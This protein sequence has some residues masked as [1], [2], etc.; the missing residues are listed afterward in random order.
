MTQPPPRTVDLFVDGRW[1]P[2]RDGQYEPAA[3]PVTGQVIGQV[4][5]GGRADAG[6]AV[7]VAGR[8]QGGWAAATAFDRAQA[9]HRIADA[10]QRRRDELARALTLDQG[11]PLHAEAYP[12]VDDLIGYWR[13]AA[14]DVLRLDGA[15]PPSRLPGARVLIERRPLGVVAVI[16]PWNWPYTMPAQVIAPALAAG[17]TVVWAPAPSTSVCSAVLVDCIADAGLPPGTVSFVPGPG[18]VVGDEIAGHPGVAAV[19]FVGSTRT[20]LSVA[21]RAAGKAQ[22]LEMGNNGPLVVMDDADLDR[23]VA[24]AIAGA[25]L[26][27]GQSCTAAERIL[28]HEA[29]RD[30]FVAAFAAAAAEQVVLGD[31]FAAQTSMGPLNNA[32]VA[33]KT[34]RHVADALARGARLIAGGSA[35]PGWP[36]GLYWQ[37]TILDDVPRDAV[38]AREETFGPV[39]PVIGV[40][41]LED[42]IALTND[43]PY[44]LMASIYTADAGTGLRYADAIRAAWVNVNE[45][46]NYWETHLPFGGGGGSLSGVGRVGGRYAMEALTQV[47]T[48]VLSGFA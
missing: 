20:G 25:F 26:C 5:Q 11:K 48:M 43:L 31:P 30:A 7:A 27:A 1:Q 12:E 24:G 2:P 38:V 16:T 8:A 44:G 29:V 22:L 15:I 32:G 41:S 4:A 42:A 47:R 28:V 19:A 6:A 34:A 45:S 37:A 10:C 46:S 3:S 36:T 13:G 40:A 21:R 9:L 33:A 39:A 23:A 17:N 35:E 14:E 18:P